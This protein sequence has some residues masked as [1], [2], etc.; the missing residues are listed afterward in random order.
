MAAITEISLYLI[1]TVAVLYTVLVILRFA[2]QLAQADIYNPISQFIVKATNPPLRPL[3]RIVP[4]IMGLDIAAIVLAV[5]VQLLAIV[6]VLLLYGGP[7]MPARLLTW[8]VLNSLGLATSLYFFTVII[9]IVLSWVAPRSYHPAAILIH[10]I[11][12]PVMAPFRR[13]LPPLGGFDFSPILVLV[14]LR[15]IDILLKHAAQA[16]GMYHTVAFGL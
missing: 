5:T 16:S 11:N 13:L 3:R 9:G 6:C 2:L 4:G 10:Q 12:E 8:A 15:V 1:R 7:L 14:C